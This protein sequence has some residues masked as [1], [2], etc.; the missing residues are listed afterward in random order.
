MDK[1][2]AKMYYGDKASMVP[3]RD[4]SDLTDRSGAAGTQSFTRMKNSASGT[5]FN[6]EDAVEALSTRLLAVTDNDSDEEDR[7][8]RKSFRLLGQGA[9]GSYSDDDGDDDE[10]VEDDDEADDQIQKELLPLSK[11]GSTSGGMKNRRQ[12][13]AFRHMFDDVELAS[14]EKRIQAQRHVCSMLTITFTAILLLIAAIVTGVEFIGPPSQPVG[15]YLLIEKQE[16]ESFFDYYTFYEGA[17]SV[18]S[19]GYLQYVNKKYALNNDI[20]RI[21]HEI[22]P[23]INILHEKNNK[24]LNHTASN[25]ESN[26]LAATTNNN[27]D[28][29]SSISSLDNDHE[30]P[31]VYIGSAS[32]PDGPRD[33]IRLEGNRRFDRGLFM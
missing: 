3:L 23:F 26:T 13:I 11:V 20:I 4:D 10:E 7:I 21:Q 33:S 30:V 28:T 16:G 9:L 32:T 15:P 6:E 25:I 17:D 27:D 1:K 24:K 12:S 18:G 19:N 14:E 22:D 29:S 2:H 5:R 8:I 31:F